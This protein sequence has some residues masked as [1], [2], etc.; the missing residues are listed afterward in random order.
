ML[1]GNNPL[2]SLILFTALREMAS[3]DEKRPHHRMLENPSLTARLIAS[4][5]RFFASPSDSDRASETA[6]A[7]S[8][9]SKI[10]SRPSRSNRP[11]P[12]IPAQFA[13]PKPTRTAKHSEAHCSNER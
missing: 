6:P 10:P 9:P 4:T 3:N 8:A 13:L 7:V 2:N 12:S 5:R 11:T 1:D